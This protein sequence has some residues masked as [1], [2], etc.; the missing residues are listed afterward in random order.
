MRHNNSSN[1][2]NS[3]NATKRPKYIQLLEQLAALREAAVTIV[4]LVVLYGR[5][6]S[7]TPSARLG[8]NMAPTLL[9]LRHG[10]GV[11]SLS[12]KFRSGVEKALSSHNQDSVPCYSKLWL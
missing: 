4:S 1:R 2:L 12:S 10:S 7:L 9:A 11:L 8:S 6:L 5:K 3:E